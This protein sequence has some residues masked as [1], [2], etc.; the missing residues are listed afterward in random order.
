MTD[1][2][3][4]YRQGEDVFDRTTG[5][6]VP[7]PQTTI[8]GPGK[9]RVKPSALSTAEQVQAG[10]REQLLSRYE[11]ALPW[12]TVPE[13]GLQPRAGDL[14]EVTASPDARLVGMLL[15]VVVAQFGA[16]ATA[17]RLQV[18]DRTSWA[19]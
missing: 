9:A 7:G 6:T 2:V 14:V 13:G 8:Y 18:E 17:W 4:L 11:V 1:T 5:Q 3:R 10:E 19:E 12:S 15:W 16:T